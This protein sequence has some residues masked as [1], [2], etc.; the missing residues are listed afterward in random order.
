[1]LE[2]SI[3]DSIRSS[4]YHMGMVSMTCCGW[5]WFLRQPGSL[6]RRCFERIISGRSSVRNEGRRRSTAGILCKAIQPDTG[7]VLSIE[8]H[9]IIY[10]LRLSLSSFSASAAAAPASDAWHS[11]WHGDGDSC[12]V[13][14]LGISLDVPFSFC[15]PLCSSVSL[16]LSDSQ[17][18]GRPVR[19]LCDA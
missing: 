4:V 14:T 5:G 6:K 10:S 13:Y 7:Q 9:L 19:A 16:T 8:Y 17:Y 2:Y 11:A 12:V 3:L 1:M 15:V 18:Q